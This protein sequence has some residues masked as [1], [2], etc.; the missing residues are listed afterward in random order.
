MTDRRLWICILILF[1][2]SRPDKVT[3]SRVQCGYGCNNAFPDD[4]DHK[5]DKPG[6]NH[7]HGFRSSGQS[8]QIR[9]DCR[10]KE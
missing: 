3:H 5:D 8:H 9:Q 2:G 1:S 4:R 10:Q 7:L 6:G